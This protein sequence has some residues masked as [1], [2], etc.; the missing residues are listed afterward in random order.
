MG[1]AWMA[2]TCAMDGIAARRDPGA[3]GHGW[4]VFALAGR[5]QESAKWRSATPTGRPPYPAHGRLSTQSGQSSPVAERQQK[6]AKPTSTG[7]LCRPVVSGH[8]R[9][10]IRSR[11][12]LWSCLTSPPTYAAPPV[13]PRPLQYSGLS[14]ISASSPRRCGFARHAGGPRGT[15]RP[16]RPYPNG[17]PWS[18]RNP[19]TSSTRRC[20]GSR[21][22]S[23]VAWSC[24]RRATP[25][26]RRDRAPGKPRQATQPA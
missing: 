7:S 6:T 26:T 14:P 8:Q 19:N 17:T 2:P 10:E 5:P 24:R 1:G 16:S 21:V 18:S 11:P 4:H 20:S 15:T 13:S 3:V 25:C 9:R 12:H 23:P 22:P